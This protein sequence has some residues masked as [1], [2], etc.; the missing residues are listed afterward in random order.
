MFKYL[1]LTTMLLSPTKNLKQYN[2]A[3]HKT[4]I[5]FFKMLIHN[6]P[7]AQ[8]VGLKL[9]HEHILSFLS[10]FYYNCSLNLTQ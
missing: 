2:H 9:Y 8:D 4:L 3:I 6:V 10:M 5:G 1:Y 7:Q